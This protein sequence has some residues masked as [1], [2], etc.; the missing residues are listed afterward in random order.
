MSKGLMLFTWFI[1]VLGLFSL[2]MVFMNFII[3][4]IGDTYTRVSEYKVA[5]NYQ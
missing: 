4:V 3:A 5:H 2:T 1:W